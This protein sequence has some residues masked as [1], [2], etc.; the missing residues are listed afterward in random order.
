MHWFASH[1]NS[2]SGV[3][4]S[5]VKSAT[6]LEVKWWT[7]DAGLRSSSF[8]EALEDYKLWCPHSAVVSLVHLSVLPISPGPLSSL[9]KEIEY[10]DNLCMLELF[11]KFILLCSLGVQLGFNM[12]KSALMNGNPM[13]FVSILPHPSLTH[14]TA[15]NGSWETSAACCCWHELLTPNRPTWWRRRSKSSQPS[16]SSERKTCKCVLIHVLSRLDTRLMETHWTREVKIKVLDSE[17]L[18]YLPSNVI[19][20]FIL[21]RKCSTVHCHINTDPFFMCHTGFSLPVFQ[22]QNLQLELV[23]FFRTKIAPKMTW[24]PSTNTEPILK[25]L[26]SSG[27]K[28]VQVQVHKVSFEFVFPLNGWK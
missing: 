21:E 22:V 16:V 9:Q 10:I 3:S 27:K 5:F 6:D 8:C 11:V 20:Y 7:T 15:C 13:D 24:E 18:L 25:K 4:G 1:V 26:F 23:M 19:Q 17:I 2:F 28:K 12:T 14:S